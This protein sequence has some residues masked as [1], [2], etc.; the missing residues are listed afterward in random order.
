MDLSTLF[1]K[2][3]YSFH[4]HCCKPGAAIFKQVINTME[5]NPARTL[6]IDDA[7]PNV[8]AAAALGLNAYLLKQGEDIADL[9]KGF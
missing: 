3:F 1:E 2:E 8:E 6:F 4:M 9:L 5:L 7:L